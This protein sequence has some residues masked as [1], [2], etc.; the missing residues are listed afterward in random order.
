MKKF[1]NLTDVRQDVPIH[2]NPL[3]KK[4][5]SAPHINKIELHDLAETTSLSGNL[6][7]YCKFKVTE[8]GYYHLS[9]QIGIHNSSEREIIVD[10]IQ[11]GV[12]DAEMVEINANLNSQIIN[13]PCCG[14]YLIAENY[15]TI[16]YLEKDADY[17]CWLNFNSDDAKSFEYLKELSHLRLY[18]L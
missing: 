14:G 18:K 6:F 1:G 15:T 12:C 5:L 9:T 3:L 10:Y 8:S 7:D 13:S 11:F 4:P 16:M 17:K 2:R